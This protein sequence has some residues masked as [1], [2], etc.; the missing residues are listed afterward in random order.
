MAGDVSSIPG[1]GAEIPHTVWPRGEKKK[2]GKHVY[3]HRQDFTVISILLH[4]LFHVSCSSVYLTIHP[5][6]HFI[7]IH[8]RVLAVDIDEIC[9]TP[10]ISVQY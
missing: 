9:I 5:S 1:Q 2:C 4:L 3:T 10:K 8:F 7:F 6:I